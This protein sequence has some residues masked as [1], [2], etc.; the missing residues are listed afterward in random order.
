MT[1][2]KLG[3]QTNLSGLIKEQIKKPRKVVKVKTYGCYLVTERGRYIFKFPEPLVYELD[4]RGNKAYS[5][6]M[7]PHTGSNGEV[8]MGDN[9]NVNQLIESISYFNL[10]SMYDV[11]PW[12][13]FK[14]DLLNKIKEMEYGPRED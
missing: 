1:A 9:Q 6:I 4:I 13:E 3:S 2:R 5:S 8:C 12:Y 14:E 10:D 11:D 7:T